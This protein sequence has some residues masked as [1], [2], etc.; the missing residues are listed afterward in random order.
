MVAVQQFDDNP[1]R[2]RHFRPP[3]CVPVIPNGPARKALD[4]RYSRLFAAGLLFCAAFMVVGLRLVEV[5]LWPAANS[6]E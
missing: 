4:R 5:A 3:L 1:C 6:R 2:P